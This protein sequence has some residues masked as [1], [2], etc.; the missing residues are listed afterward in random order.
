MAPGGLR[1]HLDPDLLAHHSDALQAFTTT[2]ARTASTACA[3]GNLAPLD[4]WNDTRG[5]PGP[6]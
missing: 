1:L 2:A 6:L 4:C 3:A 5:T